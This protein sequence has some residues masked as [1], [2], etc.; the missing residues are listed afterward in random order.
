MNYSVCEEYQTKTFTSERVIARD[1]CGPSALAYDSCGNLIVVEE[2]GHRIRKYSPSFDLLWTTGTKGNV[3]GEFLYPTDVAIDQDDSLYI[4]NRWNHRIDVFSSDGKALR[5]FGAF[6]EGV[7][8][9]IEPWGISFSKRDELYIVDRGNARIAVYSRGGKWLRSFGKC[10][11]TVDYYEGERFKRGF[12]YN[13]WLRSVSKLNPIESTF[14][15]YQF[16]IGDF[17]YPESIAIQA[18]GTI[19]VSDRVSGKVVV[20]SDSEKF[21]SVITHHNETT[22]RFSPTGVRVCEDMTILIDEL[23]QMIYFQTSDSLMC[24]NLA[25]LSIKPTDVLYDRVSGRCIIADA[26]HDAIHIGVMK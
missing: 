5:S 18:D 12:H 24:V 6:G 16:D 19:F 14:F 22:K 7:Q 20:F 2:L 23:S 17:E 13:Q 25:H 11:I 9:F 10:G 8:E 21:L 4:T 26:W 3:L 15:D 1:L